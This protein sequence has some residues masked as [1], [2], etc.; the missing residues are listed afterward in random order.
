[1]K[2]EVKSRLVGVVLVAIGAVMGIL[3]M[4]IEVKGGS[5]DP[6]SRLFP[7]LA[8]GLIIL[9]GLVVILF[10]KKIETKPFVDQ[11]GWGRIAVFMGV[12]VLYTLALK[13]IGF[14]ISTPFFLFGCTGMLA[15]GRKT[16]LVGRIL[17]SVA[18]TAVCWFVFGRLLNMSLPAGKLF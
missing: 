6:G 2:M 1:M 7:L 5:N 4:Q 18:I 8:C 3:S 11:K 16:S 12:M 15:G 13:Y 17:Y 10:A 14:L 9:C